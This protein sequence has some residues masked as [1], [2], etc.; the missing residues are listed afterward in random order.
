MAASAKIQVFFERSFSTQS[1][2]SNQRGQS[3]VEYALLLLVITTIS[4]A[5]MSFTNQSLGKYWMYF[6]RLIVD[7]P[8]Q[9]ATLTID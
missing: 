8:T 9:N 4:F 6:T 3:L 2:H 5:F 1:L 7:D